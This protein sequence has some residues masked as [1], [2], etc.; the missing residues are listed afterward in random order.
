MFLSYISDLKT[1]QLAE[2][3]VLDRLHQVNGF[4]TPRP[5]LASLVC[6]H[7]RRASILLRLE[8]DSRLSLP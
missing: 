7:R 2:F 8:N 1:A 6:V 4:N 5:R 3:P